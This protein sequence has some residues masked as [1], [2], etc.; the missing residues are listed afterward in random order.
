MK[1]Q[2]IE[3]AP[4]N[5]TE[6]LGYMGPKIF[7][8]VWYFAPSS[9]TFGWLDANGKA[10]RPTHWMPLPAPPERNENET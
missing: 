2:P 7:G 10:C 8:L 3:T 1:W 4:K 6:V 5:Q 9:T